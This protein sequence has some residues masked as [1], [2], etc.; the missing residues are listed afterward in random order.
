MSRRNGILVVFSG[1]DGGGKST[2]IRLLQEYLH[3]QGR[4]S[5]YLWTRGG[6]TPIFDRLK[7]ILRRLSRSRAVPPAGSTLQRERAFSSTR[8][9]RVWLALALLDLMW[10]YGIL[11]RYWRWRGRAVICD[12]YLW[13]TLVDFRLNFPGER[14]EHWLLWRCLV[15]V[16]PQPDAAFLLVIPVAESVRRSKLK[17]EPFPDTPARL[18]DRLAH[19]ETLSATGDWLLLDGQRPIESLASEIRAR[20]ANLGA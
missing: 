11:V 20:V 15:R 2:Q 13:D 1:I 8:V 14:A 12:R 6:Y 7:A 17:N 10:T 4:E 9:R 5:V 18:A 19:Y 3:A 16:T